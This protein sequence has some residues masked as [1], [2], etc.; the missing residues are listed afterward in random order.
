MFELALVALWLASGYIA[1]GMAKGLF[2][3]T[4]DRVEATMA[5]VFLLVGPMFFIAIMILWVVLGE[6][7]RIHLWGPH[8]I[9]DPTK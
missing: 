2:G 6:E 9:F 1:G 5:T 8:E 7:C 4:F 3:G